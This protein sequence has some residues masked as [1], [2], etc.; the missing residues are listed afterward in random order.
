MAQSPKTELTQAKFLVYLLRNGLIATKIKN[1]YK[2]FINESKVEH[3]KLK[4][5]RLPVK[6]LQIINYIGEPMV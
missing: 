4:R 2:T 6:K 5:E 3:K 1:Q